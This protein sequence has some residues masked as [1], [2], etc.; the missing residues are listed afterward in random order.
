[1]VFSSIHTGGIQEEV[2]ELLS[3]AAES[4]WTWGDGDHKDAVADVVTRFLN[5]YE[6]DLPVLRRN[7]E[8]I[9]GQHAEQPFLYIGVESLPR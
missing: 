7:V 2:L 9:R 4:M 1:M 5:A 3:V 8:E 6:E